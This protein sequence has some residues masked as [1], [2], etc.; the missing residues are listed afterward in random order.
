MARLFYWKQRARL[1]PP[2]VAESLQARSRLLAATT[3]RRGGRPRPTVTQQQQ[4]ALATQ[5][6]FS[7]KTDLILN[8]AASVQFR[9][10]LCKQPEYRPQI[11]SAVLLHQYQKGPRYSHR[12]LAR[13]QRT[14]QGGQSTPSYVRTFHWQLSATSSLHVLPP[15][16]K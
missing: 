8:L 10:E 14:R 9:P 2:V 5:T 1:F 11:A 16:S 15:R 4:R 7:T 13:R 6:P 12:P 3:G